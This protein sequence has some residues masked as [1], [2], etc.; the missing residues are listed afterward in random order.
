MIPNCKQEKQ[1]NS[2]GNEVFYWDGKSSTSNSN[3]LSLWKSIVESAKKNTVFVFASSGSTKTMFVIEPPFAISNTVII[4]SVFGTC[5]KTSTPSTGSSGYYMY[6][7]N[8]TL[9]FTNDELNS[10]SALSND[11]NST[12]YNYLATDHT[13]TTPFIPTNDSHPATKKYVDDNTIKARLDGT[14]LYLT[15]DSTS[16]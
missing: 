10:I 4:S 5:M 12:A 13:S 3:N 11:S 9:K 7:G 16:P 14:T 8:V 1:N 2:N 15:N 6:R